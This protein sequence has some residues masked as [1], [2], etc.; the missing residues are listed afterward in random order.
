MARLGAEGTP[1]HFTAEPST[2]PVGRVI[3]DGL[4]QVDAPPSLELMALLF[5]ADRLDHVTREVEPLLARGTHVLTDRYVWSSLA[6]QGAR[7]PA[8][9][10]A[11]LNR[12]AR[13]PD[14]TILFDVAPE[15]A[16]ERR[17]QR[18]G[19]VEIYDDLPMQWAVAARY[20]ALAAEASAG[21]VAILDAGAGFDDVAAA[22]YAA[23]RRC[24][25]PDA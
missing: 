8:D 25:E 20:R 3:R 19:A 9:W 23:V 21:A 24:L 15:V 1:A 14:L 5:A 11:T 13:R 16:L 2:G 4:R 17:M 6:Y 22:L 12:A 18:G 7:L 10:V